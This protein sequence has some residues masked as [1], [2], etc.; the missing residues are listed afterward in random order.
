MGGILTGSLVVAEASGCI[1]P[2]T[3]YQFEDITVLTDISMG[4]LALAGGVIHEMDKVFSGDCND[5]HDA[6]M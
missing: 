1:S 4:S 2:I 6:M 3:Y 5:F